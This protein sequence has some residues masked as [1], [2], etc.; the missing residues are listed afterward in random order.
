M[1]GAVCRRLADPLA[2]ADLLASVCEGRLSSRGLRGQVARKLPP[3]VGRS[4]SAADSR[5]LGLSRPPYGALALS[6]GKPRLVL[7]FGRVWPK[8][9]LVWAWHPSSRLRSWR[10]AVDAGV[11][12]AAL[13]RV[14]D[15]VE[16][17]GGPPARPGFLP[18]ARLGGRRAKR[19]AMRGL[20]AVDGGVAFVQSHVALATWH[21][22]AYGLG[23]RPGALPYLKGH[24]RLGRA[25]FHGR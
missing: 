19:P 8:C 6:P 25:T 20:A 12:V 7:K 21:G 17:T 4:P 3:L 16:G 13:A 14:L 11:D 24:A 5:Q 15:L 1:P 10:L 18:T 2:L 22:G 9:R 23:D